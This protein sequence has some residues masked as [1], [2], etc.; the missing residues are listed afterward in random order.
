MPGISHADAQALHADYLQRG[1]D[2]LRST[3]FLKSPTR[4][5][6]DPYA[7]DLT[8][9]TDGASKGQSAFGD[10]RC[11]S[12]WGFALQGRNQKGNEH[13]FSRFGGM[14][15]AST[16]EAELAGILNG[17][18]SVIRPATVSLVTDCQAAIHLLTSE[19][20]ILA[21]REE[22]TGVPPGDR[23]R[24]H[25]VG[26][27]LLK[28]VDDIWGEVRRNRHLLDVSLRW[29]PSHML[30][31]EQAREGMGRV[32]GRELRTFVTD[33]LGNHEADRLANLGVEKAIHT[34]LRELR[35]KQPPGQLRAKVNVCR[36]NFDQSRACRDIA[37]RYL[38][39]KPGFLE[40]GDLDVLLG[41]DAARQIRAA[42]RQVDS[43]AFQ[44][45]PVALPITPRG[46]QPDA[47]E[48]VRRAHA[49]SDL[50]L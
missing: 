9:Y 19:D 7:F 27:R 15:K 6:S 48:P 20:K 4:E 36:Q 17:L 45:T 2:Q 28:W 39:S 49:G 33:L 41:E 42:W 43:R 37:V 26:L 31:A 1:N 25:H 5:C 32:K 21:L 22:V 11:F 13:V 18:R 38:Q 14:F 44:W 29:A 3:V 50:S 24:E 16:L 47:A 34:V 10:D 23:K 30:S 12:G 35:Q 40:P 8:V 46:V